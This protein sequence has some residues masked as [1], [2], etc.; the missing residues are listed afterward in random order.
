MKKLF[1]AF[2]VLLF[3]ALCVLAY[4]SCADEAPAPPQQAQHEVNIPENPYLI[5]QE[6]AIENLKESYAELIGA[7]SRS[8][9]MP[10]IAEIYSYGTHPTRSRSELE[11]SVLNEVVLYY[12]NFENN[13]GF[14]VVSGDVRIPESMLCITS[15]GRINLSDL[16]VNGYY[17]SE[18]NYITPNAN[19]YP[20]V[21]QTFFT[22][23][24]YPGETFINPKIH[25]FYVNAVGETIIGNYEY[26][27]QPQLEPDQQY[28]DSMKLNVPANLIALAC[29]SY[30]TKTAKLRLANLSSVLCTEFDYRNGEY[31]SSGPGGESGSETRVKEFCTPWEFQQGAEVRLTKYEIWNQGNPYNSLFP[32]R[33]SYVWGDTEVVPV[34]C[35]PISI[36]KIMAFLRVPSTLTINNF[37]IDW[38]AVDIKANRLNARN[39]RSNLFFGIAEACESWYFYNGTYTFPSKVLTFLSSNGYSNARFETYSPE[40]A[41]SMINKG[42]PT[43]VYGQNEDAFFTM[44][45]WNID[46]YKIQKRNCTTVIYE[47]GTEISRTTTQEFQTWLHCDFGWGGNCNGY[48][49]GN[50]F[51]FNDEDTELDD[52]SNTREGSRKPLNI[53]LFDS[54]I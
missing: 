18:G 17:D 25:N 32:Q 49:S 8:C 23:S 43:L 2:S 21:G 27:K 44:H 33:H 13:E 4:S 15:K 50:I 40:R 42:Y 11:D 45:V 26:E 24:E 29:Q 9:I 48:F 35:F 53:L 22:T 20:N 54:A 6:Q 52:S 12:I 46:G 28:L 14:A 30:A 37:T 41:V 10:A 16:A 5:S 7:D 19:S 36:A 3:G 39:N 38:N 34:G 1:K 31:V 51:K 47:G